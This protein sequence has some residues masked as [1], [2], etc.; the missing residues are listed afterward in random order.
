MLGE[1]VVVG[2]GEADVVGCVGGLEVVV[3]TA[4]VVVARVAVSV[5]AEM[6][7]ERICLSSSASRS[8]ARSSMA[9]SSEGV[10]WPM[11]TMDRPMSQ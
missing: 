6:M 7:L 5:M 1:F 10:D 9:C 11:A 8:T 3:V 4:A 2:D